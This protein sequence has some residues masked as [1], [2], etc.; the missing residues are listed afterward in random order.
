MGADPKQLAEPISRLHELAR[1]ANKPT[2]AVVL[3][4]GFPV[5]DPARAAAQVHALAEVGVTHFI[6]GGRYQ[7]ASECR[8]NIEALAKH[9]IPVIEGL[10][11]D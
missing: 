10:P 3:M 11:G 4:T 1:V 7:D 8:H 2:P 6:H 5:D 9:V